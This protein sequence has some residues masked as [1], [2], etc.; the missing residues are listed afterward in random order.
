MNLSVYL[1]D[2]NKPLPNPLPTFI[3]KDSQGMHPKIVQKI[4][5]I[6]DTLVAK[7]YQRVPQ[8][9]HK[10]LPLYVEV[11]LYRESDRY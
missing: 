3:T 4:H 1:W 2:D 6:G 5:P 11:F 9:I 7:T 8:L 10:K